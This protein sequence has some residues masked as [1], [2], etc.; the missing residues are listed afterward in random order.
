MPTLDFD[1][2][3]QV[4]NMTMVV[5]TPRMFTD[6][7]IIDGFLA[8]MRFFVLPLLYAYLVRH[9]ARGVE[10]AIDLEI[11]FHLGRFP[12]GASA[13]KLWYVL[14]PLHPELDLERA[15]ICARLYSLHEKGKVDNVL[16]IYSDSPIWYLVK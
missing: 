16:G 1:P 13:K 10:H 3:C 14:A 6:Q 15:D 5:H 11:L 9:P 8:V 12:M 7:Q 4:N 2:Y